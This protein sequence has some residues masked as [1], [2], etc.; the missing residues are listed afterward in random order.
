MKKFIRKMVRR[1]SKRR[2]RKSLLLRCTSFFIEAGTL[3]CFSLFFKNKIFSSNTIPFLPPSLLV[4]AAKRNETPLVTK[5]IGSP[6]LPASLVDTAH[7]SILNYPADEDGMVTNI[8]LRLGG[9]APGNGDDWEVRIYEKTATRAFI[10]KGK[11]SIAVA[12]RR[13]T[14]QSLQVYPPLP[15]ERGQ[16]IGLVNK[17]GRLSLTYTRGWSMQRGVLGDL[18]DLWYLEDQPMHDIG[19]ATPPLLMWNGRVGWFATMAQDPPE[20]LM[21]VPVCT[22]ANDMRRIL[23]D[24]KTTDVTFLVGAHRDPVHAHRSI[25]KA[26][27]DFFNALLAGGFVEEGMQ[28]VE[29][30][31]ATPITFRLMLEWLY[32]NRIEGLQPSE[33]TEVLQLAS[34]YCITSLLAKC[35]MVRHV[36]IEVCPVVSTF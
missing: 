13:T 29:I 16:Y 31:D 10:L 34:K 28:T 18:W 8:T 12:T 20:P 4:R 26:R 33:A 27:C 15:I 32:T 22:L 11:Q 30:P 5:V 25:I 17:S 36:P 9:H 7:L 14:E 24:E 19:S 1:R 3:P 23:E 35:E 21:V 2:A 6:T